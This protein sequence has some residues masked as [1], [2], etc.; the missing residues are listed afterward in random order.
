MLDVMLTSGW[1]RLILLVGG[2]LALV[3]LLLRR[4]RRWW[5]RVVPIALGLGSAAAVLLALIVNLWWRPF[6]DPLPSVSLLWAGLAV[7][8]VVLAAARTA[9]RARSGP[10]AAVLVLVVLVSG[11]AQVNQHFLAYP[12]LRAALGLPLPGQVAFDQIANTGTGGPVTGGAGPLSA[13]WTAPPG[14]PPAGAVTT[15]SI[16]GPSSGFNPRDAWIYLPPAYLSSPRALLPVV[17]LL[18]GQPSTPRDWL[19]GG[20]LT[21][22][23]N[24]YAASHGGLAPVVVVP[25][26]LGSALAEPLCVDSAVGNAATYLTVDVP[27]WIRANLQVD[28]DPRHWAVAGSSAG[29][30]CALQL[31]VTAPQVYP[32][33]VDM[34]GQS[35]PTVGDHARTVATVFGGDEAAFARVNPVD[36]LAKRQLPGTAGLIIVGQDDTTFRPQAQTVLAALQNAGVPTGYLELPGGHSW[37]VWRAGF[38]Q[39]LPFLATRTGLTP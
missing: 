33:F 22:T 31:A 13:A 19:D 39:S 11:A 37:Q 30:T 28:A 10:V 6:P 12:T 18:P 25:D 3:L 32:T 20:F 9:R 21:Q 5:V 34:S 4:D 2:I 1:I 24:D 35:E 27:A 8:A 14:M 26:P 29:G 23:M 15:T 17:V 7:T 38:A 16:P 36:I